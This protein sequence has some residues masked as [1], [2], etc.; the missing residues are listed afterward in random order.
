MTSEVVSSR[1]RVT[2]EILDADLQASE[3]PSATGTATANDCF[4]GAL[5]FGGETKKGIA[6]LPP[7]GCQGVAAK[8]GV[9]QPCRHATDG[10]G[11]PL[12]ELPIGPNL[13]R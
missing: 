10:S 2:R 11:Y 12:E 4:A 13:D 3:G 6:L 8:G 7:H 9:G 5:G 1:L